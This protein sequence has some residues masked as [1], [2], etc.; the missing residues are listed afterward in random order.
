MRQSVM[1]WDAM[2]GAIRIVCITVAIAASTP[3]AVVAHAPYEILER[4]MVDGHGRELRL[5]LSYTDGIVL[6]DPVKLVVR[7]ADG[8]TIAETPQ[9]RT[10][11]VTCPPST[12]C[13]VFAYGEFSPVPSH[14]WWLNDGQLQP[15]ECGWLAALGVVAPLWSDAWGYVVAVALLLLPWP[16]LTMLW[17]IGHGE[18]D[19][20]TRS[21]TTVA[22][23]L[24]MVAATAIGSVVYYFS[25]FWML[26]MLAELSPLLPLGC[27]LLVW[28][29]I[30]W[31]LRAGREIAAA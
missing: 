22:R 18:P 17:R 14:V 28:G 16:V 27:G 19:A 8:R 21:V 2:P 31:S 4:V 10:I 5:M 20:S 23:Q 6:F 13:V 15:T 9:A 24:M 25:Y 29:W 26:S 30:A 7:D 11:S 12:A 1:L 3:S